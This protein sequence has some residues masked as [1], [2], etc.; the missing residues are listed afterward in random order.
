[1]AVRKA[2][3]KLSREENQKATSW[4]PQWGDL[5]TGQIGGYL[6]QKAVVSCF[7]P[8]RAQTDIENEYA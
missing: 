6:V 1:M 2:I 5:V 8:I 7:L 3:A 4:R